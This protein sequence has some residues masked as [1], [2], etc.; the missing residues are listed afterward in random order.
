MS[1]YS[2]ALRKIEDARAEKNNSTMPDLGFDRGVDWWCGLRILGG[3][4]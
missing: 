3:V 4:L 1:K 2:D